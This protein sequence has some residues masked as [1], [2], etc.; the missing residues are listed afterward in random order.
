MSRKYKK[1]EIVEVVYYQCPYCNTEYCMEDSAFECRDECYEDGLA[2]KA[3]SERK[4]AK[5]ER[6]F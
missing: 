5:I 1:R 6:M 4:E 3:D 2:D